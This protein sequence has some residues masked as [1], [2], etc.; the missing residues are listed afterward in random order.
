MEGHKQLCGDC[1]G[2]CVKGCAGVFSQL[3]KSPSN[4]WP[5]VNPQVSPASVAS[6][7]AK[8]LVIEELNELIP[9]LNKDNSEC[10]SFCTIKLGNWID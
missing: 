8:P 10:A 1:H 9:A 7:T 3:I 2:H 5:T 4:T 6:L